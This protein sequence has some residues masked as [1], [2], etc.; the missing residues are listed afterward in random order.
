MA[1]RNIKLLLLHS[2]EGL[3]IVGDVVKVK[4][5]HARNFLLPQGFAEFPTLAK[6]KAL[7]EARAEA[8]AEVQA[9]RAARQ[10]LLERMQEVSITIERSCN[11]Q[12]VLYGSVNQ[13]DIA[14]ALQA[15][16]YDVGV[17]SVRLSQAIRRVGQYDVL[18]QFEKDLRTDV[19]VVV[20]PDRTLEDER[21]EMEFDD[22]GNLIQQSKRKKGKG[23]PATQ[24]GEQPAADDESASADAPST[25]A[26][27]GEPASAPTT[28]G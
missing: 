15:A 23:R 8:M 19:S 18:V 9:L 12:G 3:G 16:G 4:P 22:E 24:D 21:E 20:E 14:D 28:A 2:V 26:E 27:A 11:D 13:R 1:G 5:G 25:E 7:E 17:R 6:Q 10:E